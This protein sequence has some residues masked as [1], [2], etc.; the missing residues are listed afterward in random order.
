MAGERGWRLAVRTSA[1]IVV[2]LFAVLVATGIYLT[3]RY[4][5]T[6]DPAFARAVG[7]K[8]RPPVLVSAR[9]VHRVAATCFLLAVAA[10]AITSIG[11]FVVRRRLGPIAFSVSQ[12]LFA[13]LASLTGFIIAWDQINLNAVTVGTNI[14]GYS[15]ILDGHGIKYVLIGSTEVR[16]ATIARWFWV[17]SV[18]MPLLI[19]VMFVALFIGARRTAQ[20][21]TAIPET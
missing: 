9:R 8:L 1:L 18:A 10:L 7:I 15:R 21:D 4:R 2:A 11:L 16:S 6:M 12:L 19:I 3:F 17:H 13:F 20:P 5:P 14:E